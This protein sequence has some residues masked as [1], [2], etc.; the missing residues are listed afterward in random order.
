MLYA[1][2]RQ[3]TD[4]GKSSDDA[5]ITRNKPQLLADGFSHRA[6][7]SRRCLATARY[8]FRAWLPSLPRS[9]SC[10]MSMICSSFSYSRSL[11]SSIC[12]SCACSDSLDVASEAQRL[13][14]RGRPIPLEIP[15][16]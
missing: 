8:L 11:V 12:C 6:G 3:T 7:F 15:Y 5:Q 14:H 1:I 10:R 9:G 2:A 4:F 13:S 16:P